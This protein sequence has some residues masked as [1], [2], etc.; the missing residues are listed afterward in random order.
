MKEGLSCRDVAKRVPS[1]S[2]MTVSR[3][4][5]TETGLP[6]TRAGRPHKLSDHAK[7]KVMRYI[8]RKN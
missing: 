3:I 2:Q 8:V 5:N 4:L 7:R 6:R 1:V